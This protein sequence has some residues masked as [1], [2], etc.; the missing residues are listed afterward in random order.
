MGPEEPRPCPIVPSLLL[1]DREEWWLRS[2]VLHSL[3]AELSVVEVS[4]LQADA[5]ESVHGEAQSSDEEDK[6]KGLLL[7]NFINYVH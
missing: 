6:L 3:Q 5:D 4:P 7:L 2:H 1:P